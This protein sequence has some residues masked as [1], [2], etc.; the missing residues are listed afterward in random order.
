MVVVVPEAD[1]VLPAP[2]GTHEKLDVPTSSCEVPTG[3]HERKSCV[4]F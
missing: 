1:P 2:V 4:R 3:R